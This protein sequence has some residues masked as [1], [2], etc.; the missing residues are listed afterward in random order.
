VQ[1]G[2]FGEWNFVRARLSCGL[3]AGYKESWSPGGPVERGA[4]FGTSLYRRF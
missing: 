2:G 4:Y 3:H 1:A